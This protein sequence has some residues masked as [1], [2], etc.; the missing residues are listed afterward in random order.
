M[1]QFAAALTATCACI[2]IAFA[3]DFWTK[4][5]FAE[6]SEKD[7]K[8][9]ESDSPWARSVSIESGGST[10]GRGGR[11]ARG[12]GGGI[13]ASSGTAGG[14]GAMDGLGSSGTRD[15]TTT[16]GEMDAFSQISITVRWESALP[17]KQAETKLQLGAEAASSAEAAKFLNAPKDKYIISVSGVPQHSMQGNPQDWKNSSMIRSARGKLIR[18]EN[19]QAAKTKLGPAIFLTFPRGGENEITADDGWVEVVAKIGPYNLVRRFQLKEMMYEGNL[20]M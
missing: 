14:G 6:W 12:G 20:E 5:P 16:A 15:T 1:K 3:A 10:G 4:K 11:G 13:P 18:A 7:A 19:L 2:S 17:I 8:K 9:L